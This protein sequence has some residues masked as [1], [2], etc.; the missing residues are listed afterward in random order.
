MSEPQDF[1]PLPSIIDADFEH[2]KMLEFGLPLRYS[3]ID[4][5]DQTQRDAYIL[6]VIWFLEQLIGDGL[7]SNG[8][9]E[10]PEIAALRAQLD[11]LHAEMRE[12]AILAGLDLFD[13]PAPFAELEDET[14]N[15]K[16]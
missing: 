8:E 16:P 6:F 4:W 5:S 9:I 2:E 15:G 11:Q 10:T 13:S 12:N 3:D 14:P 7:T 1:E